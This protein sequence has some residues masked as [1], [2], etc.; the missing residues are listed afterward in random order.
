MMMSGFRVRVA[1]LVLD[2]KLASLLQKRV[3]TCIQK[4]KKNTFDKSIKFLHWLF[5]VVLDDFRS[6]LDTVLWLQSW[7]CLLS[8]QG[9][10]NG[11]EP[12]NSGLLA[13]EPYP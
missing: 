1:G 13:V 7:P 11:S 8:F 12:P 5:L 4:P 3:A 2:F 9:Q 6:L 10:A